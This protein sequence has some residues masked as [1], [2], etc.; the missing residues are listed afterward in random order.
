MDN[1]IIFHETDDDGDSLDV[2]DLRIA[3]HVNEGP[4]NALMMRA[5]DGVEGERVSVR[6]TPGSVERLRDAL[7]EWLGDQ[8]EPPTVRPPAPEVAPEFLRRAA[9]D[10]AVAYVSSWES[11]HYT[12]VL[13]IASKFE[14]RLRDGDEPTE[15]V[16]DP[17]WVRPTIK[18]LPQC[19][20]QMGQAAQAYARAVSD[21][22]RAMKPLAEPESEPAEA[23]DSDSSR[24]PECR[25]YT[26]N[27]DKLG[28]F[29]AVP[30]R[31]GP[32]TCE[33]TLAFGQ[34]YVDPDSVNCAVC[35]HAPH[36][37][38]T[39]PCG[40][41][42]ANGTRC[43]CRSQSQGT[44]P[45]GPCCEHPD[46]AHGPHGCLAQKGDPQS[47]CPCTEKERRA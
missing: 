45:A 20:E 21:S 22:I 26:D 39:G 7:N 31:P 1:G 16:V 42:L 28:C 11:S 47:F 36:S 3:P 27:H 30:T 13:D 9:L 12:D 24:C 32:T 15:V 17:E 19:L 18:D 37:H 5:V 43:A 10:A 33:C 46:A 14:T 4:R 8:N 38:H 34:K 2:K 23:V 29:V 40:V 6:L 35:S 44:P 25:H 41:I